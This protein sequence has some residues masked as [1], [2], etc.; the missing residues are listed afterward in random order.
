M[1]GGANF[2]QLLSRQM[3]RALDFRL[4]LFWLVA[5]LIPTLLVALPL[6]GILRDVLDFS[7]Y[8]DALAQRLNLDA[9]SALGAAYQRSELAI[10]T[11]VTLAWVC[12]LLCAP[13]LTALAA[14]LFMAS[15]KSPWSRLWLTGL[16][17]YGRWFWL[18]LSAFLVYLL[19]FGTAAI[20]AASAEIWVE[21]YVNANSFAKVQIVSWLAAVLIAL[22]TH[23]FVEI[24]RAEYILD[25][26][27]RFPP[28]AFLRAL[29]RRQLLRRFS[30]YLIVCS[31]GTSLL[32]LLFVL[33]QR[34]GGASLA[35]MGLTLILAQCSVAAIAW[36]RT[37][38]L[39]VLAELAESTPFKQV[40]SDKNSPARSF[41]GAR[42]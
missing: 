33:R 37:A 4:V 23:F 20:V 42:E 29:S 3:R 16:S 12:T 25:T 5:S 17:D 41:I 19:G 2:W 38:R 35:A 10:Q 22:I 6:A 36:M 24:A 21:E 32:L 40:P 1:R 27:L 9:L 11:N 15:D 18:H 14:A 34:L 30:G 8:S 31:A 7:A 26:R 28:R 13:M 39:F